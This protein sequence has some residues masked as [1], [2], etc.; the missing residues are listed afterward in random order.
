MSEAASELRARRALVGNAFV[1]ELDGSR[2]DANP[3]LEACER[4]AHSALHATCEHEA[5]R[6]QAVQR[7]LGGPLA[8]A[9]AEA[10]RRRVVRAAVEA[11]EAGAFGHG[12]SR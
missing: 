1:P 6:L 12:D 7:S 2:A 11:A 8:E 10:V 9:R 5:E 3:D 4:R